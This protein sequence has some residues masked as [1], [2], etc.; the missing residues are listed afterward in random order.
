M[1]R[2]VGYNIGASLRK[3]EEVDVNGEGIGWGRFLRIIVLHW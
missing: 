2:D 1:N 3:V